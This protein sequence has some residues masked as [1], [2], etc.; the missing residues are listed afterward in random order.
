MSE[1]AKPL[2]VGKRFTNIN[3]WCETSSLK[4]IISVLKSEKRLLWSTVTFNYINTGVRNKFKL[5][6]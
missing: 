2:M 5:L 6:K 4:T 1:D 3:K